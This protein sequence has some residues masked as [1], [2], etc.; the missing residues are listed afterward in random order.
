LNAIGFQLR[1]P[2]MSWGTGGSSI[3]PSHSNPTWSAVVGI[4]GAGL[5]IGRD[6]P[7]LVDIASDFALAFVVE[8]VGVKSADYHTV[9]SPNARQAAAVRPRSRAQEL[10]YIDDL[11]T[12]ITRREYVHDACYKVFV[13]QVADKPKFQLTDIVAAL[14]NPVFPLYAGRRSCVIGRLDAHLVESQELMTAT[15]WDSRI[16]LGKQPS[17]VVERSDLLVGK[18]SFGIRQE[19]MA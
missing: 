3:I 14:G 4:I 13:V 15:H 2:M 18:R 19:C 11:S 7:E 5:G 10:E 16:N 6:S 8:R 12:T 9:Q 1:V 17:M